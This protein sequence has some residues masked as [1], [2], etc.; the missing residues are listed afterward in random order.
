[1][2]IITIPESQLKDL[3][4]EEDGE[5]IGASRE[6]EDGSSDDATDTVASAVSRL[7]DKLLL[8]S[9]IIA[10]LDFPPLLL[11]VCPSAQSDDD[12]VQ[13][14]RQKQL[15]LQ[16]SYDQVWGDR[17]KERRKSDR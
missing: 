7:I 9:L 4:N 6:Q 13:E 1:M 16:N 3:E 11:S 2:K 10:E 14:E 8:V 12:S 5:E 15:E 17:Q